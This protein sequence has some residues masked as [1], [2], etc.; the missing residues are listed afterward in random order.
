[1]THYLSWRSQNVRSGQRVLINETLKAYLLANMLK[2]RV[3]IDWGQIW[4]YIF[5]KTYENLVFIFL[6]SILLTVYHSEANIVYHTDVWP[7]VDMWVLLMENVLHQRINVCLLLK[8]ITETS[9]PLISFRTFFLCLCSWVRR[10][11]GNVLMI[12]WLMR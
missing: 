4:L 2:W 9:K 3:K 6:E 5:G 8:N 10:K 11:Q 12:M 1:M 7:E